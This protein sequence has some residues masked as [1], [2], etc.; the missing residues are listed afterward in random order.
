MAMMADRE[1]AA[2]HVADQ[3]GV[4][5][6]TLYAYVDGQGQPKECARLLLAA[7]HRRSPVTT[8]AARG[9]AR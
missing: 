1:N 5:L 3:L 7:P 6:S 9:F 4:S 2:R 8:P